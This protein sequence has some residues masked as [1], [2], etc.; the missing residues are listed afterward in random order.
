[1]LIS[2]EMINELSGDQRLSWQKQRLLASTRHKHEIRYQDSSMVRLLHIDPMVSSSSPPSDN[3]SFR[4][5]RVAS[6]LRFQAYEP[7]GVV[8]ARRTCSIR[9]NFPVSKCLLMTS[10]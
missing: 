3:L 8:T 5:K 10:R 1:M 7:Q 2:G 4:V 6:S 9:K